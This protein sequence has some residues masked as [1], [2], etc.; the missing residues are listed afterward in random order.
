MAIYSKQC[1]IYISWRTTNNA[2]ISTL[3]TQITSNPHTFHIGSIYRNQA[4]KVK[5]DML[6]QKLLSMSELGCVW[7]V[8]VVMSPEHGEDNQ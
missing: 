6:A 8:L 7:V 4:N 2:Y 3:H 1:K 5:V